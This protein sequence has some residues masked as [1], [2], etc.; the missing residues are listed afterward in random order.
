MIN[1]ALATHNAMLDL[2]LRIN[3]KTGSFLSSRA[4]VRVTKLKP[5]SK[6]L[7]DIVASY[8]PFC[9]IAYSDEATEESA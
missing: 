2:P 7:P 6:R 1:Q 5:D 9:G 4:L 3:L 8:C